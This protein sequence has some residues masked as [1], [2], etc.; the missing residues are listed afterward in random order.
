MHGI[1]IVRF[2]RAYRCL[3]AVGNTL[4]LGRTGLLH[5]WWGWIVC[6]TGEEHAYCLGMVIGDEELEAVLVTS[7]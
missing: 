6:T 4:Y 5:F 2:T 7:R 1:H 3:P